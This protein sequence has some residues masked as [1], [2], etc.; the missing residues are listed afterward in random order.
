MNK[1]NFN[2]STFLQDLPYIQHA[3]TAVLTDLRSAVTPITEDLAD[4]IIMIA[5]QLCEPDPR[6]R[7]D[8]KIL[9][10]KIPQHDLQP[11][12]SR[13]DRLARYAELGML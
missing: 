13:F 3:F 9:S 1:R 8:P 2:Q 4:E 11:Y 5:D 7:G 12:I 6:R 10:S